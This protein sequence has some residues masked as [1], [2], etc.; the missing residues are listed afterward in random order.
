LSQLSKQSLGSVFAALKPTYQS[1]DIR[2]LILKSLNEGNRSVSPCLFLKIRLTKEKPEEVK[3]VHDK[4]RNDLDRDG[5]YT[6]ASEDLPLK[7]KLVGLGIDEAERLLDNIRA[8]RLKLEGVEYKIES[9]VDRLS[10]AEPIWSDS[11]IS[12]QTYL[13]Y[14]HL[15]FWTQRRDFLVTHLEKEI[16]IQDYDFA[17]AGLLDISSLAA[18]QGNS[19]LVLFPVYCRSVTLNDKEKGNTLA[20]YEIQRLLLESCE[21]ISSKITGE[22]QNRKVLMK[23]CSVKTLGDMD[24]VN[25]PLLFQVLH[26]DAVEVNVFHKT[27]GSIFENRIYG[28]TILNPP[29]GHDLLIDAFREFEANIRLNE[30]LVSKANETRKVSMQLKQ[31]CS[32]IWLL[33]MIGYRSIPLGMVHTDDERTTSEVHSCDILACD[34]TN[35]LVIDCTST[36]PPADKVDKIC[37][38]NIF[39]ESRMGEKGHC[40][41]VII[42]ND[43]CISVK[44]AALPAGVMIIDKGDIAHLHDLLINKGLRNDACTYFAG[45]IGQ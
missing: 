2:A 23:D 39:L 34:D 10:D 22:R 19:L 42:C 36:P 18:V 30:Y 35:L 26:N 15:L 40:T 6:N 9:D 38:T 41:P 7:V 28:D 5:L 45:L 43:Y 14:R 27:L 8:S 33:N 24:V 13:Q 29:Y 11:Y 32:S 4:L 37:N 20:K 16:N 1:I 12:S 44:Q 17:I 25:V 3:A 31:T 21:V